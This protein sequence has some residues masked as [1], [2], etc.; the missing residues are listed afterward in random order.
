MIGT[1][2]QPGGA[3]RGIIGGDRPAY[4][5]Q[6]SLA[7][8]RNLG[9][10]FRV[11]AIAGADHNSNG[12]VVFECF[13]DR[14]VRPISALRHKHSAETPLFLCKFPIIDRLKDRSTFVLRQ[15]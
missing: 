13:F 14:T 4:W 2:R 6:Q 8:A 15:V 11:S 3:G 5:V 9:S 12:K 10:I 7:D 1:A